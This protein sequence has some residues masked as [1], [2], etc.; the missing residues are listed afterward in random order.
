MGLS[1]GV[2]SSV[3][4]ALAKKALGRKRLLALILPC[5]SQK[6]D[7]EDAKLVAKKLG[8]RTETVDL[9]RIYDNLIKILPEAGKIAYANLKPRLRMLTLYYFG[10]KLN[11][12]VCGTGNKSEIMVGY[13]TKHGDGAADILP[14][15]DLLKTQVKELARRLGIPK[16]IINK[17]P[18]AGLWPGQTDEGELGITYEQLDDILSKFKKRQKQ[19]QSIYLVNRVKSRIKISEHKRQLPRICKI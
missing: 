13:T 3:V 18:S 14:I 7:L 15:G 5:H 6:P 11:Y 4:A 8:I 17:V 10:N 9:S 1:G 16:H 2:D 12:L 19:V